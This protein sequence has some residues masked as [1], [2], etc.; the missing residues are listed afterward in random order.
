MEHLNAGAAAPLARRDTPK[1]LPKRLYRE[2]AVAELENAF[3]VMLDGKPALTPARGRV[4]LPNLA[5]A[6]AVAAEWANQGDVVNP[7][8]MPL[9]RLVNSAIDGVARNTEAVRADVVNY[10]RSDLLC[11]RAGE[12]ESLVLAQNEAWT[13]VLD[14]ARETFGVR[15]ALS[16]GVVFVEQPPAAIAAIGEAV[17]QV[18]S[19]IALT[20]V[21]VMTTLTGSALLALAVAAGHLSAQEAWRAAHI[22]EDFQIFAWGADSESMARRERRWREME[23]AARLVE[24]A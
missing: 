19:P 1:A 12:P 17:A 7:A 6:R 2:V 8:E 9:T 13:P 24:P 16:Q 10:A 11:Y 5:T 14:W 4:A 15:L 22:D 18:P 3:V 21:H 20:A 23:A